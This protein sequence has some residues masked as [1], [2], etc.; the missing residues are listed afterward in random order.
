[1]E[2]DL[3]AYRGTKEY[4]VHVAGHRVNNGVKDLYIEPSAAALLGRILWLGSKG[5]DY[6]WDAL[7]YL[8]DD[9]IEEIEQ[10]EAANREP[11]EE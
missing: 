4:I 3:Y 5:C 2:G 6:P 11:P 10:A 7:R 8:K 1:M 9:I